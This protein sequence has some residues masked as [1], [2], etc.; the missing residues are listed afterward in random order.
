MCLDRQAVIDAAAGGNGFILDSVFNR[1]AF[2]YKEGRNKQYP[3]DA[4]VAKKQLADLDWTDSDGNKF[5]DKNGEELNLKLSYPGLWSLLQA[6]APIV[7]DNWR[8]IGVNVELNPLDDA[9]SNEQIYDNTKVEK[10]YDA[11][12]NRITIATIWR[13]KPVSLP[14]TTNKLSACL[15][16]A[17]RR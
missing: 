7:Y 3:F 17:R 2:L 4:E 13:M 8:T 5:L 14:T 10:A 6:I 12:L 1:S 16:R 9:A 11:F 15:K